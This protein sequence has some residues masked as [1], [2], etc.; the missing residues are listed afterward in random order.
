MTAIRLHIGLAGCGDA[1]LQ[2]ALDAKRA[3]LL[4]DGVLFPRSPGGSN[5]TR[6][7][8]AVTDPERPEPLRWQRGFADPR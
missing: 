8:M 7:F 6:L 1:R 5:H 3:R 4:K 2:A